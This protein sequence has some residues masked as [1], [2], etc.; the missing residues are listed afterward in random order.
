MRTMWAQAALAKATRATA[1]RARVFI[2][3]APGVGAPSFAGP[4]PAPPP[5]PNADCIGPVAFRFGPRVSPLERAGSGRGTVAPMLGPGE[6]FARRYVIVEHIGAGGM[7]D[8]Y[9]AL[10]E[11]L[12]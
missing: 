11:E 1:R 6:R 10:D 7:G 8:V 5:H 3:A 2:V 4:M 9:A 12:G